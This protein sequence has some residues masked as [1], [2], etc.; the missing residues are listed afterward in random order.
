MPT[1]KECYERCDGCGRGRRGSADGLCGKCHET[2]KRNGAI[3]RRGHDHMPPTPERLARIE[4]LRERAS[5][6]L[7]LFT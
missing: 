6:G 1:R 7:P 2:L 5:L 3:P 4:S